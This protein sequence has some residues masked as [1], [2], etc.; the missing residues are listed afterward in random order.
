M[1]AFA[2]SERWK[3]V[4]A[5]EKDPKILA[6]AK[7]NADIYGIQDKISWYEGDCFK[8][9]TNEL[10]EISNHSILFASPPWGG[11]PTLLRS[12]RYGALMT[13]AGPG[14]RS[15]TVY[16]L[17]KMQPYTLTDLLAFFRQFTKDIA[18]YLPRSSDIR[19][20][21]NESLGE[22]KM[23]IMHYCAEGASKVGSSPGER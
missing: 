15:D 14:Y 4:Y 16:N 3:R 2:R 12:A 13:I 1:I 18:L 6:C 17:A 10:A 23:T 7:H 8:I 11:K 22:S 20:L 19:Q 21:A 9:L 5:I